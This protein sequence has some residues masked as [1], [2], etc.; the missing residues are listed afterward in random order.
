MITQLKNPLTNTYNEFKSAVTST[1][2][3]WGYYP[4]RVLREGLWYSTKDANP[5]MFSHTFLKRPD[6]KVKFPLLQ[7]QDYIGLVHTVVNEILEYNDIIL[8]CF[9]SFN[10]NMIFPQAGTQRTPL[11]VD[12][13][14][15]HDNMIIYFS[16]EGKT[17]TENDEHDPEED[18]VII[19][20]GVPHC[21]ELPKTEK[22]LVLVATYLSGYHDPDGGLRECK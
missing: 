13:P 18:D 4:T 11:H 8:I 6:E 19:F 14:F 7:S 5:E 22:R 15:P 20:P 1:G 3:P 2:F 12:H 10:L 21:H 17:L 9:Y 16:N